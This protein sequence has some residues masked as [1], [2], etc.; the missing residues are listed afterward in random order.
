MKRRSAV[1]NM[2]MVLAGLGT[3]PAWVSC[4]KP[5]ANSQMV[6]LSSFD[7]SLLAE[8]VGTIIPETDTSGAKSLEVNQFILRMLH[9]CYDEEALASLKHGL[10]QTEK[11][12]K[13]SFGKTFAALAPQEREEVLVR[14][15]QSAEPEDTKAIGLI[16]GLTIRGYLNSEYVMVN[17]LGYSMIPPAYNGCLP[18]ETATLNA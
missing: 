17:L 7:E 10:V 1:K 5:D 9:D 14:L 2:A 13:D 16:K 15:T 4:W 12:A 11:V 18:L 3:I 6:A 8:I